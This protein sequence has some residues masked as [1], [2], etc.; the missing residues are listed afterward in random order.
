MALVHGTGASCPQG[1]EAVD[2]RV[3]V[4]FSQWRER[5]QS[6]VVRHLLRT[7]HLP[8]R[9]PRR[10]GTVRVCVFPCCV[11]CCSLLFP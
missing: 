5:A 3:P 4:K 11:C 9:T 7:R 6:P 8:V 1:N 2:L 10:T